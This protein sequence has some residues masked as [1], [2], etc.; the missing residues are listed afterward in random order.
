MRDIGMPVIASEM[1]DP[2]QADVLIG[3]DGMARAIRFVSYE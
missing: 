1:N 2:V 3:Q